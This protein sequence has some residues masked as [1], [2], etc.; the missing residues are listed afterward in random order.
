VWE[1]S[2]EIRDLDFEAVVQLA[3]RPTRRLGGNAEGAVSDALEALLTSLHA[4]LHAAG[5]RE[6]VVDIRT[7]EFMS[8]AC[9]NALVAW[10]TLITE[11]PAA[12]RYQLQ[13]ASNL[14][15]PWQRRSLDTLACFATDLVTV[16]T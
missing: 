10:L 15:I 3:P 9:F 13:F 12:E 14:A 8:A 16:A 5:A 4:R 1:P 2:L 7:L 11:L 6:I